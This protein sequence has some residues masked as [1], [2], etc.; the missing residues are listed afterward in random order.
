MTATSTYPEAYT[1]S[2]TERRELRRRIRSWLGISRDPAPESRR[3]FGAVRELARLVELSTGGRY[4]LVVQRTSDGGLID[5]RRIH[6][7]FAEV[8]R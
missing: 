2:A 5:P 7:E 1:G 4:K 3:V 6:H 8:D